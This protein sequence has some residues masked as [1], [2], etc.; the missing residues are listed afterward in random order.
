MNVNI[1]VF[2]IGVVILLIKMLA[3]VFVAVQAVLPS[4]IH[5]STSAAILMISLIALL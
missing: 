4:S 3:T 1:V 2:M 5:I